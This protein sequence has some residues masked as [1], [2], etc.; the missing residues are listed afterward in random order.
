MLF[1]EEATLRLKQQL[2]VVEDRQVAEVLGMTGNAWTMRK[3]RDSFPEKELRAVA[4]QRPDLG[5]DV[6][7]ILTGEEG[8][9]VV[10][11]GQLVEVMDHFRWKPEKLA[12][13]MGMAADRTTQFCASL[14]SSAGVKLRSSEVKRLVTEWRVRRE[15][16]VHGVQPML[17]D[18]DDDVVALNRKVQGLEAQLAALT[19]AVSSLTAALHGAGSPAAKP[20]PATKKRAPAKKAQ[21]SDGSAVQHFHQPVGQVAGRDI[22]NN[23]RSKR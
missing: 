9:V 8:G 21:P 10:R 1:F 14:G 23:P 19:S 15:F 3:R 6:D 20:K 13:E 22:V 12:A 17:G 18:G 5:L 4:Q 16:L 7:Y 2:K 11:T